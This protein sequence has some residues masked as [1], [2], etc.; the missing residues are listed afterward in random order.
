MSDLN[1]GLIPNAVFDSA[2]LALQNAGPRLQPGATSATRETA[3]DFEAFF[4]AQVF[5]Q[6]FQG[7]ET[8]PLFGG[9]AGEEIFQS[10][11]IQEYGKSVAQ[12]GG[13]GIADSV[14]RELIAMQEDQ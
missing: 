9:G 8:D 3:E 1:G 2:T 13:I 10:L 4:L 5:S 11:M 6:M 12:N 7:V 14:M